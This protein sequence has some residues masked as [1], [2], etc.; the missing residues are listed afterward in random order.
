MQGCDGLERIRV[1]SSHFVPRKAYVGYHYNWKTIFDALLG[2]RKVDWALMM[3]NVVRR[4]LAMV[5]KSKLIP[6]CLYV[7]HLYH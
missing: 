4:L 2:E 6:S 3:R 7:F 1:L 5:G